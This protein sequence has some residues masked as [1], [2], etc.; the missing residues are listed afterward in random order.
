MD[1]TQ[2]QINSLIKA[3]IQARTHAY[4]PFSNYQVGAAV[5]TDSGDVISAPNVETGL[6]NLGICAERMALFTAFTH[7]HKKIQ[8]LALVT[9]DGHAPCG[10]CRQV[11]YQ[12]CCD[13]PIIIAKPDGTYTISSTLKLL[14]SPFDLRSCG[15]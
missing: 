10:M 1:L 6:S 15:S 14:P 8:A 5:L 3:A 2:K 13:I 9:G 11:I 12:L 7:G 4:C